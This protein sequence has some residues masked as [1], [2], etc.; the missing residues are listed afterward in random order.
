[1]IQTELIFDGRQL[2]DKGIETAE[3]TA[4]KLDPGFNERAFEMFKDWLS[5]WPKGY[6][7]MMEEF[8]ES[9]HFRGLVAPASKRVFGGLALKAKRSG[10]IIHAGYGQVRNKMA[11][12]ANASQWEK[13]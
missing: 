12:C 13:V 7:F 4:E 10:L 6:R 9:A 3:T 5:G 8:R 1:M 11:H 2:R